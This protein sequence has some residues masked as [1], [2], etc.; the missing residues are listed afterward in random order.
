MNLDIQKMICN[1]GKTKHF[2]I[3]FIQGH[4]KM[5]ADVNSNKNKLQHSF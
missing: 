3:V 4:M 1:L 5:K 2:F